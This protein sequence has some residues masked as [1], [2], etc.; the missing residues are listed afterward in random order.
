MRSS[1][2][3][4]AAISTLAFGFAAS[5]VEAAPLTGSRAVVAAAPTTVEPVFFFTRCGFFGNRCRRHHRY[6]R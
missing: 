3:A 1:L 6:Y 4:F 5:G 2:F